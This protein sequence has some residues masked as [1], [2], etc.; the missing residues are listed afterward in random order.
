MGY[1]E[2]VYEE[3]IRDYKSKFPYWKLD[4][5]EKWVIG[6]LAELHTLAK[7]Q[8]EEIHNLEQA[9]FALQQHLGLEEGV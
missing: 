8:S 2:A 4:D 7:C 1:L 5:Q 3:F 9:V 6:R